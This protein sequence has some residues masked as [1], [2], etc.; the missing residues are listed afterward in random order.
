[1]QPALDDIR[2]N[3]TLLPTPVENSLPEASPADAAED[4]APVEAEQRE[5]LPEDL[6]TGPQLAV[7]VAFADGANIS[8]AARR[9]GVHRSSIHNWLNRDNFFAAEHNRLK[10]ERLD[11]IEQS[12]HDLST[13]ALG[14]LRDLLHSSETSNEL[15][16]RAA[17]EVLNRTC[18]KGAEKVGPTDLMTIHHRRNLGLLGF[19]PDLE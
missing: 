6:L 16:L 10:R 12:M 17:I 8:E 2:H 18:A 13:P 1:M 3:S 14:V 4:A 5:Y 19:G 9:A 11:A 15:R 7:L